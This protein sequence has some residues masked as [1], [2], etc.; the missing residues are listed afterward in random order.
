MRAILVILFIL[1]VFAGLIY[2]T[3]PPAKECKDGQCPTCPVEQ[4]KEEPKDYSWHFLNDKQ[5]NL[6][7]NGKHIGTWDYPSSTFTEW[8][9]GA[10]GRTGLPCPTDK[11]IPRE[12][13]PT[14]A[15]FGKIRQGKEYFQ[16]GGK[17]VSKVEFSSKAEG[18]CPNCPKPAKPKLPA[19]NF[20]YVV[21]ASPNREKLAQFRQTW[22]T[23]P[24]FAAYRASY[25]LWEC[26]P[27][28]W[29]VEGFFGPQ[30][31]GTIIQASDGTV[32]SR[33]ESIDPQTVVGALR[34]IKPDYKR[35]KD[36]DL[37]RVLSIFN[38]GLG[39]DL[40]KFMAFAA[41]GSLCASLVI[42]FSRK[43]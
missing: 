16:V 39:D 43:D 29:S 33:S 28:H 32:E 24:E 31:E 21:V 15:A 7:L 9:D 36:P 13:L 4:K 25:A 30:E 2:L 38:F 8:K 18:P 41:L 10:W 5:D 34:K 26:N 3:E 11:P 37:T 35:D 17:E 20:P 42:H 14:G 6:Y 27:N 1:L 22:D 23:S 12:D 19:S 40:M